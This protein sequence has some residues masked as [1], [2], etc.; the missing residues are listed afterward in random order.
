MFSRANVVAAEVITS[1][2][3]VAIRI[4]V[5]TDS[6]AAAAAAEAMTAGLIDSVGRQSS[7]T[8]QRFRY[9]CPPGRLMAADV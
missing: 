4:R 7:I 8:C 2:D 5:I 6:I 1:E 9:S 3:D